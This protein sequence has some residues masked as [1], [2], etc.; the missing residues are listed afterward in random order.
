MAQEIIDKKTLDHLAELSRIQL[1]SDEEQKILKDLQEILGYFDLLKEI[2]TD[3]IEPLAGGTIEQNVFREEDV[4]S[5]GKNLTDQ[6]LEKE[7][8]YLKIPP[9]FE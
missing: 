2:N 7:D 8:N 1:D 4:K 5:E 6:F 3:N 9:V